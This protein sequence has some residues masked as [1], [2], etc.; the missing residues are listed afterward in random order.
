MPLL[1]DPTT[2]KKAVNLSINSDLLKAARQC[3]INLSGI[4]ESALIEQLKAAKAHQWLEANRES[5]AAYNAL[6]DEQGAFSDGTRT[7]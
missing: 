2:P 1:F 5:I 3:D 4:L 7:F 6:V